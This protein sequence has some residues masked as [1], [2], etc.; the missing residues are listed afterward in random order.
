MFCL[1]LAGC[2]QAHSAKAAALEASL[3]QQGDVLAQLA[4][5]VAELPS[6]GGLLEVRC[7][8]VCRTCVSAAHLKS[9]TPRAL[10]DQCLLCCMLIKRAVCL[11]R[12][13]SG[14]STLEYNSVTCRVSPDKP[15]TGEDRSHTC[16]CDLV[17]T[18]LRCA[19]LTRL[20]CRVPRQ[21]CRRC[22]RSTD[23]RRRA[24]GR[25]VPAAVQQPFASP[26]T[27]VAPQSQQHD[28]HCA[29]LPLDRRP[30]WQ[31]CACLTVPRA[32][33]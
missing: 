12:R 13:Q 19:V 4:A 16:C 15:V 2:P 28:P 10:L 1:C 24:A 32:C 3:K 25:C 11:V 5:S 7:C 26:A 18:V 20:L 6:K 17:C 33:V 29:G 21:L 22:W 31:Q 9:Y 27:A 23:G 8:L 14:N 30:T